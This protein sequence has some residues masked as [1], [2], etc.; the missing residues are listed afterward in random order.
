M[1]KADEI[2]TIKKFVSS[3]PE[4]SYLRSALEPFVPEFEAG[5][6]SDI[7]PCLRESWN[8]RIEAQREA[9]EARRAIEALRVEQK[10][11]QDEVHVQLRRLERANDSLQEISSSIDVAS[12][13]AVRVASAARSLLS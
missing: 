12:R 11:L 1:T 2:A 3:L 10:R 7:V 13:T 6:Y 9:S 8:A 5:V 4:V